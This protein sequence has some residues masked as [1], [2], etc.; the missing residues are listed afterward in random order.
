[1]LLATCHGWCVNVKVLREWRA[2]VC[3]VNYICTA[4]ALSAAASKRNCPFSTVDHVDCRMLGKTSFATR[5]SLPRGYRCGSKDDWP[6]GFLNARPRTFARQ[7]KKLHK[8]QNLTWCTLAESLCTSTPRQ[9]HQC[10]PNSSTEYAVEVPNRKICPTHPARTGKGVCVP[11][12]SDKV[13]ADR[14]KVKETN[15]SWLTRFPEKMWATQ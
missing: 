8:Q 15:C 10:T 2:C 9:P 12:Q 7:T 13:P 4:S 3:H 6:P 11:L 14:R 5:H 1:M